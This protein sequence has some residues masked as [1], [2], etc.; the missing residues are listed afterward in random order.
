[1]I[2]LPKLHNSDYDDA[3]QCPSCNGQNLHQGTV[4]VYNR[5]EDAET[6]AVTMVT[7]TEVTTVHNARLCGNPSVRR[8]GLRISM[9][10]EGC[11]EVGDMVVYQHKGCTFIEWDLNDGSDT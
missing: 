8:H 4:Y 6:T 7:G 10:C 3:L 2:T 1:M 5:D 9:S 11:G